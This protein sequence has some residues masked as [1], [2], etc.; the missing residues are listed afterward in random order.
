MSIRYVRQV[1][2]KG[3]IAVLPVAA[4]IYIALWLVSG[5]EAIFSPLLRSLLTDS[6]YIPGMGVAVGL[7]G[8]FVL[9]LVLQ[10]ILARRVWS[11][12]ELMLSQTPLISQVY[13]ALKQV[14]AYA[15]GSEQPQGSSVVLVKFGAGSAR[16][17]GLV[18]QENV[19]FGSASGEEDLVAVFLPWSYQ[20]GGITVL[21]SR[22]T[23]EPV[24]LTPQEAFRFSLTAGVS[25][26]EPPG[27]DAV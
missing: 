1:F 27:P 21:V 6:G 2:F 12:G 17:L 24:N 10:A 8:I 16:M 9:G 4:T 19:E 26:T 7:V 18:T 15:S 13:Q 23:I 3:L 22:D 20:I 11:F 5:F 14:V 25:V